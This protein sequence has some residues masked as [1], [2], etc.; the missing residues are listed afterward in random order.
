MQSQAATIREYT[1]GLPAEARRVIKELDR[2][3][4]TALPA[5]VGSMKYGMPTY[6]RAGRMIAFN[7]QKHYFS[8]YA[9]P[10][11]VKRHRAALGGLDVG[12][13]CIRFRRLEDVSLEALRTI[14]AEHGR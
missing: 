10:E 12:K 6:E 4:R 1:A 7:S 2:L 13:S 5:A 8:F 3:V 11:I 9:D 14:V